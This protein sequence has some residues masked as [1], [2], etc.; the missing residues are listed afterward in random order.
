MW[1]FERLWTAFLVLI[2]LVTFFVLVALFVA[3]IEAVLCDGCSNWG[4]PVE[5][6]YP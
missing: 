2:V 6:G 4:E 3:G 1:R 5:R